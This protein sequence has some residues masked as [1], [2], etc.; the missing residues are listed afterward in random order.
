MKDWYKEWQDRK[1]KEANLKNQKEIKD[2]L[3]KL[4]GVTKESVFAIKYD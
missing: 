2:K 3:D 1:G 4:G